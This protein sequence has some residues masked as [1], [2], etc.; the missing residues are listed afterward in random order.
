MCVGIGE[1]GRVL[2]VELYVVCCILLFFFFWCCSFCCLLCFGFWLIVD[3]FLVPLVF[4]F[5]LWL[6][7]DWVLGLVARL[8]CVAELLGCW[9]AWLVGLFLGWGC[10]VGDCVVGGWMLVVG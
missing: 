2:V 4:Q 1:L 5:A 10:S 6:L 7:G 9:V 8:R 3:S